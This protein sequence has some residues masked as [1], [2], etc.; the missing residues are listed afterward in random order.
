MTRKILCCRVLLLYL[1]LTCIT[2]HE[3]MF[4]TLNVYDE[5]KNQQYF[6]IVVSY[7]ENL[8]SQTIL[9]AKFTKSTFIKF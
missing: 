2:Y 1:Y 7:N 3:N 4:I 8:H 9:F 5:K 6:V